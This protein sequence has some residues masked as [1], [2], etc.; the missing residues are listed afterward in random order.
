[1]AHHWQA[2][3]G[4]IR[5]LFGEG[6]RGDAG[7]IAEDLGCR[8]ILLVSDPGIRQA[9]HLQEVHAIL[10]TRGLDV[11]IFDRVEENPSSA[12]VEAGVAEA[13]P[14]APDCLIALGGGS[15]MD[16][17]KGINFLLTNGG[18]MADFQGIG[19]A[20]KPLLPSIGIPTTA[21]TGSEAQSFALISDT[22]THR[23]MACGDSQA[24]FRA[25][26]LDP[27]LT[28]SVPRHVA[29]A[30]GLDA[31]S[32][33]VETYVSTRRNPISAMLASTAWRLLEPHWEE[34]LEAQVS[35]EIRGRML[36]AA[37]L[38]GAAIEQSML[39]AA[40]A[41]ANP[42]TAEFGIV[43][44][45][46]VA[47]LLP[48]VVRF[49][50]ETVENHYLDLTSATGLDSSIGAGEALA[51]RIEGMRQHAGLPSRL[52]QLGVSAS[53]LPDLAASA[54]QEWTA[55]FNPRPVGE[56]ELLA[57]YDASF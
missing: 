39:G 2:E 6:R 1:M 3:I 17:A 14:F 12:N 28:A 32:H 9:G 42:L 4:S 5:V 36:L 33:A 29:A 11:L 34:T 23:K 8:R 47:L 48:H 50:A 44:G 31:V 43:H 22:A 30:A 54:A 19:R 26:I 40:H 7:S 13:A 51:L 49:N 25:V 35:T 37:H 16:C 52:Q 56:A 57:L 15:A 53:E 10:A 18:R 45:Q 20:T 41:G 46:A 55:R 38:A 24:R 27:G 21:G